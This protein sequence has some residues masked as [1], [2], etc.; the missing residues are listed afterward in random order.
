MPVSQKIVTLVRMASRPT[1]AWFVVVGSQPTN[2]SRFHASCDDQLGGAGFGGAD[3]QEVDAL[4]VDGG[5]ELR[6]GVEP[7]FLGAPVE[8]VLPVGD[9]FGEVGLAD[10]VV[11]AGAGE[12]AGPAGFG[13]AV[14][15]L[16][17]VRLGDVD[18][19]R[20]HDRSL[21]RTED[22]AGPRTP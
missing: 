16:V 14:V 8:A 1:G 9:E 2:H 18:A 5:R 21:P 6:E 10:A 7:R 20:I 13:E 11:P 22:S 19:E 15:Q 3:V 17:E 4:A 12:F